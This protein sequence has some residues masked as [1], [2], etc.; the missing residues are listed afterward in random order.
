[1]EAY[2]TEQVGDLA[3]PHSIEAAFYIAHAKIRVVDN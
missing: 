1:M 3:K 2:L